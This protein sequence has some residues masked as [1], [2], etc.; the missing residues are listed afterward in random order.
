MP[1]NGIFQECCFIKYN[2]A[3]FERSCNQYWLRYIIHL[4]IEWTMSNIPLCFGDMS[5]PEFCRQLKRLHFSFSLATN[6]FWGIRWL[7]DKETTVL[8][9]H[10]LCKCKSLD[11]ERSPL[12]I[13]WGELSIMIRYLRKNEL[14]IDCITFF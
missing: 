1:I 9:L 8:W 13:S 10:T 14:Y 4:N 2:F 6:L 11:N 7:E 3:L 5:E 12:P